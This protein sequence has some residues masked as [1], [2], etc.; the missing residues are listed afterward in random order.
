MCEAASRG[1][2]VLA[3]IL[4]KITVSYQSNV[5]DFNLQHLHLVPHYRWPHSNFTD[6][7]GSRKIL[8]PDLP[9]PMFSHF[10]TIL[11]CDIHSHTDTR[12]QYVLCSHSIAW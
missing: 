12:W 8:V 5:I 3:D 6:I 9:D 1:P 10:D 7:F 2:S 11:V 4:V